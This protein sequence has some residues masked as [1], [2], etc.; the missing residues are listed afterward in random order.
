[1]TPAQQGALEAV[2]TLRDSVVAAGG[3][4]AAL[5]RDMD[6][7]TAGALEGQARLITERCDAAERQRATS[8]K[9]LKA[10]SFP[11]AG[12]TQGQQSMLSSME[13]LKTPL[14][15]CRKT[16]KPLGEQGKGE[17]V[18]GYGISRSAPVV[19]GFD[20]FERT[21]LPSAKQMRLPVRAVLRAGPSPADVPPPFP[22][23]PMA[24]KP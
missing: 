15:R 22:T 2:G 21:V 16:F 11:E 20:A 10:Q 23:R 3:A 6:T 4:L 17:E 7:K 8:I 5:R 1:L 14:A 19:N 9:Q 12:M 24:P 18:R 13:K